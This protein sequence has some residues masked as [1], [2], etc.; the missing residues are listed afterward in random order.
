[1]EFDCKEIYFYL[2][3]QVTDAI[4][5]LQEAQKETEEAYGSGMEA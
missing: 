3:N 5:I 1:M 4:R 2:F